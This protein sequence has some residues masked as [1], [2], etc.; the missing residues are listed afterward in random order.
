MLENLKRDYRINYIIKRK[1][2]LSRT[3]QLIIQEVSKEINK[4]I[5]MKQLKITPKTTI[6][7]ELL[8]DF[9]TY[10]KK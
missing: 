4:L 7:K 6:T 10:L 3:K 5:I 9:L 2:A 1:E 8:N